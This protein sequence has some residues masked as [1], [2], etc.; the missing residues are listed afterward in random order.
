[1][2]VISIIEHQKIKIASSFDPHLK[3]I[4]REDAKYLRELELI[5]DK[6]IFSWGL[7]T[8]SPMQ[9]IGIINMPNGTIEI[10]PKIANNENDESLR[11]ILV[12]MLQVVHDVPVR[13]NIISNLSYGTQGFL[14]VLIFLFLT[15]LEKQSRYGMYKT[16]Q[17]HTQNLNTIKGK[18]DYPENLRKNANLKHKFVCKYSKF[19]ED[20]LLNQIIRF[21]LEFTKKI[22]LSNQNKSLIKR[23]LVD[24]NEVSL[25]DI[26]ETDLNKIILSRNTKRFEETLNYCRLFLKGLALDLKSGEVKINFMLF[27]MNLLFEKYIYRMFKKA[28]PNSKVIYQNKK[29][30]MLVQESSLSKK[31]QLKPDLIITYNNKT[32]VLDTK[33]K[34][35]KGFDGKDMYQMNT[36]LDC[37]PK[38]EEGILLYPKS[39]KNDKIIDNYEVRNPQNKT[40]IKIRTVDLSL[41]GDN[42]AFLNLLISFLL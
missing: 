39:T 13:K 7:N 1:M 20:N 17:K 25:L 37:I 40:V 2:G 14:D 23:L 35:N 9:W 19:S 15:E 31:V 16:Y 4:T 11:E 3:Q 36:Y 26:K 28:L 33:W 30:Y 21:T 32:F 38:V 12:H 18:V 8:V 29:N 6:K 34:N 5:Q 27:D 10:L 41:S 22:T 24:F 42:P